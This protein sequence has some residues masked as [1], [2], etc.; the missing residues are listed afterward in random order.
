MG[1][2]ASPGAERVALSVSAM[3]A[4][5]AP[6]ICVV[7]AES[8]PQPELLQPAPVSDQ[9][10]TVLGLEPDIGGRIA[11]IAAVADG[12]MAPGAVSCSVKRLVIEMEMVAL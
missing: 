3:A 2:G 7:T 8:V 4:V 6:R 9:F 1:T 10:R 5:L 11:M 12:E